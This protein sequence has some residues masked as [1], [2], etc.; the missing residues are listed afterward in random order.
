MSRR[1]FISMLMVFI[2]VH[3]AVS[4]NTETPDLFITCDIGDKS[5]FERQP[6]SLNVTLY[7]STPDIRYAR[8]SADIS[9]S[10]GEFATLQPVDNPGSAYRKVID[11]KQ[12]YCFPLEAYIA[13]F[14]DN[15]SY[16]IKQRSFEVG[17]SYPVVVNDPFWGRIR[18]SETKNFEIPVK[19]C[20][21]KVKS[22]P[23]PAADFNFSGS[24]GEFSVET[25]LP[26]GDIFL[27]EEALAVIVLRGTGM[28]AA[29]TM[30]EYREAFGGALR[31]KSVSES[32]SEAYDN[33]KLVSELRLECTFIPKET[34]NARIG[35]VSFDYFDPVKCKYI[36]ARSK[37]LN[38]KVK[39]TVSRREKMSI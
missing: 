13:T 26:P 7:S 24:V 37:P 22:L 36:T 35:E 14:A 23:N 21:F 8:K 11:G 19:D 32:R 1:Y 12:Y 4:A 9:L 15:G 27:N 6:V 10:S 31:L 16:R 20:R 18:S 38:V 29:H 3:A 17:V 25:I 34:E 33:G 28:I 30:P 39:S 5:V 2:S